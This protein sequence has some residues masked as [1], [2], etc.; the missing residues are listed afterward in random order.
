MN[1]DMEPIM[2]LV[3]NLGVTGLLGWFLWYTTSISF[4]KMNATMMDRMDALMDRM[5]TMQNKQNETIEKVCADFTATIRDERVT[6]REEINML[7]DELRQ[8]RCEHAM[9]E[10]NYQREKTKNGEH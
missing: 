3:S 1:P 5:D 9:A 10:E 2:A 7:R 4:P 6:R 8:T